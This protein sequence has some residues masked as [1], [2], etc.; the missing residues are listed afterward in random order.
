MQN[1][2]YFSDH[3]VIYQNRTKMEPL[4]EVKVTDRKKTICRVCLNYDDEKSGEGLSLFETYN[5]VYVYEEIN[6]IASIEIQKDDNLPD[7]ICSVCLLALES[8]CNF[9]RQCERSDA[10]LHS[11]LGQALH[12]QFI[13]IPV[14]EEVLDDYEYDY[15]EE[16]SPIPE[17]QYT[18][19]DPQDIEIKPDCKDPIEHKP[20]DVPIKSKAIDLKLQCHD[21]GGSFKSKCKLRVH[22]KRVHLQQQLVCPVCKK[23]HKSYKSYN[24]HIKKRS[25]GCINAGKIRIEGEGKS[26]M[27]HCRQCDTKSKRIHTI[28]TH[29]VIHTGERP[30][31][32]N[33]CGRTFTQISSLAGHKEAA[34][35]ENIKEVTCHLCG[36]HIK[37]RNKWYRHMSRHRN[38][39]I[40]CSMCNK[41]FSSEAGLRV[42]MKRHSDIKTLAC[43]LCAKTFHVAS[44][45]RNHKVNTHYKNKIHT[46]QECDYKTPNHA[47]MSRHRK[48]HTGSNVACDVCGTFVDNEQQLMLHKKR[49]FERNFKCSHCNKTFYGRRN[50]LTHVRKVHNLY[51]VGTATPRNVVKVEVKRDIH[52]V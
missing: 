7:R 44:D 8:A 47:S 1:N 31:V 6:Y 16:I 27:F 11:Q 37:G 20:M 19:T 33:L 43:D 10:M 46:C 15:L 35:K 34:H 41:L 12:E 49:H 5:N 17:Q 39:Q 24:N 42:H 25:K 28:M 52:S 9:K 21:C 23:T 22:W 32:C 51:A 45:L 30:Y 29:L 48:R 4:E 13:D 50:L 38:T 40:T 14:K 26:R 18:D 3:S 2:L 36:K